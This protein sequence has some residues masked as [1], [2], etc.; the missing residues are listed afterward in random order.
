[1]PCTSTISP[2]CPSRKEIFIPTL[3]LE[4]MPTVLAQ[5]SSFSL[6][7][8][9]V[10]ISTGFFSVWIFLNYI[11]LFSTTSLIQW[12]LTSMCFKREWNIAFLLKSIVLWLSQWTTHLSCVK[13]NS[14]RNHFIQSICLF[15]SFAA[16]YSA[17]VVDKA[18]HFYDFDCHDTA[19]PTKV[20]KYPEVD[21]L[22]SRSPAISASV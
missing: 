4:F 2:S 20:N 18:T 8:T 11:N 15:A 3:Q 21:F 17:S 19:P 14:W 9:L 12:Y 5:S 7:T 22:P 10:N 16:I 1:V 6:V 13:P